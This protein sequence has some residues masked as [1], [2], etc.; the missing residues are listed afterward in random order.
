M[1]MSAPVLVIDLEATCSDDGSITEM[2]MEVIEV[3]A[4][5]VSPEGHI[6]HRFQSFVCPIKRPQLT[7]FCMS[8]THIEQSDIDTAPTW[9]IVA[10]NL[11]RF[12]Q[13]YAQIESYW[14]S[15]GAYDCRQIQRECV[16]HRVESPLQDLIHQNLKA[17]FARVRKIK[18]VGMATALKIVGLPLEGIHHRALSDA[19]NISRLV[20]EC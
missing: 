13:R 3:G 16:R 14:G 9:P 19:L 4:V 1:S 10:T 20:P 12:V 18:Q 15:W 6:V 7:L 2:D 8:L 17:N 5:W 11:G